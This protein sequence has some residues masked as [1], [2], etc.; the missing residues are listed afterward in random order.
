[1]LFF[2][3]LKRLKH[4]LHGLNSKRSSN[5]SNTIKEKRIELEEVQFV[6]LSSV[7]TR[8]ILKKEQVVQNELRN[9]LAVEESFLQQKSRVLWVQEGDQNFHFFHSMVAIKQNRQAIHAI[10]ND[11]GQYLDGIDQIS[12]EVI[13]FFQQLLGFV[14]SLLWGVR[15]P[16]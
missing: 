13:K 9:L 14:M 1:M 10:T 4:V 2:L 3:K 16:S 8:E 7:P 5:L 6:V 11:Q 12:E 15:S